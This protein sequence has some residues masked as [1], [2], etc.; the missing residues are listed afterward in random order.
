MCPQLGFRVVAVQVGRVYHDA[1]GGPFLPTLDALV[2]VV[3][4]Y[5]SSL[6]EDPHL[7]AWG[8]LL[9]HSFR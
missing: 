4:H 3:L 6:V 5:V 8:F 1:L 2:P 9:G 7:P